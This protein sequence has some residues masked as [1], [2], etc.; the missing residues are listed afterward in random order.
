MWSKPF[1]MALAIFAVQLGL[2]FLLAALRD[3]LALSYFNGFSFG[4]Y[5][6]VHVLAAAVAGCLYAER[7]RQPP[8]HPLKLKTATYYGLIWAT[9]ISATLFSNAD[10]LDNADRWGSLAA[11]V[12]ISVLF[13]YLTYSAL[14][15]AARLYMKAQKKLL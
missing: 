8:N 7:H 12:P 2:S 9:F 5:F 3:W 10:L 11:L 6:G 14:G 4:M 1:F 15:A 13:G